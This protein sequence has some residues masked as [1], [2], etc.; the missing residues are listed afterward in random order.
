M[1]TFWDS[2]WLIA[3]VFI[4]VAYLFVLFHIFSD[5]FRNSE[6]SGFVKALWILG[7]ILPIPFIAL[8]YIL[9]HGRGMA[10][11]Q[12]QTMERV[13]SN[14]DSYIRQTA[15]KSPAEQ[16]SEAKALLDSGTISADEFAQL[17]TK[18]LA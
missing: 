9:A 1:S 5:V 13:K 6:M 18:A 17:K 4:F 2:F 15:G 11:R 14:T 16:I 8:I 10:Q 7:L 12:R 3:E